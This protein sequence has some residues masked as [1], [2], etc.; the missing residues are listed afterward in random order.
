[1]NLEAVTAYVRMATSVFTVGEGRWEESANALDQAIAAFRQIGDWN[2]LGLTLVL[3]THVH[4]FKG[5]FEAFQGVHRHIADLAERSGGFQHMIWARDGEAESLLRLGGA[6]RLPEVV[7]RL[8]QNLAEMDRPGFELE[9]AHVYSLLV[10]AHLRRGDWAGAREAGEAGA[11]IIASSRPTFYSQLEGYAGPGH[12]FLGCWEVTSEGRALAR[13]AQTSCARLRKFARIFPVARPRSMRLDG[14]YR[15]LSGDRRG[16]L[17]TW[18]AGVAM[19]RRL[20]MRYEEA[21]LHLELLRRL[22]PGAA[23]RPVHL[24]QAGSLLR[25]LPAAYELAELRHWADGE[26]DLPLMA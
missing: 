6:D 14:L 18:E 20:G 1:L 16:A 9:Q 4:M 2:R 21:L 3:R 11:Q 19:A 12:A 8:R 5:E 13:Q 17:R 7:S 10:Q 24:A 23:S 25:Q 22:Q 15:W 26:V